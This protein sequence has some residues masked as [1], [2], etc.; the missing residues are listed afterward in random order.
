MGAA[1]ELRV[2]APTNSSPRYDKNCGFTLYELC[3]PHDSSRYIKQPPRLSSY[4]HVIYYETVFGAPARLVCRHPLPRSTPP[5]RR[6]RE[7]LVSCSLS[8]AERKKNNCSGG[9][10]RER[11]SYC[12]SHIKIH[13]RSTSFR[14]D[15]RRD[16]VD[17]R[18]QRRG[19][20]E[21][22]HQKAGPL[23]PSRLHTTRDKNPG[24]V[25]FAPP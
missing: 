16:A 1:V 10:A 4:T 14:V 20:P 6:P 18:H 22:I 24:C 13:L 2:L 17:A 15:P 5:G 7:Q 23:L 19:I 12:C 11:E 21:K 9:M 8:H 3:H 25:S